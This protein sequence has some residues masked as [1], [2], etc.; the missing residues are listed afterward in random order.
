MPLFQ[1]VH[2]VTTVIFADNETQAEALAR[3]GFTALPVEV[4]EDAEI[5]C[6][7]NGHDGDYDGVEEVV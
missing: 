5:E 4:L 2:T 1:V 6:V 3:D 7:Q